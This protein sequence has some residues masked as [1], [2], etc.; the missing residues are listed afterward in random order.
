M[1]S[2]FVIKAN[3]VSSKLEDIL[4]GFFF[5]NGAE[6]ISENL[7]FSQLDEEYNVETLDKKNKDLS[8]YFSE[9]PAEDVMLKARAQFLE[10]IFSVVEEENKDWMAEWKKGFK[11]FE[12][13]KNVFV[14]PSWESKTYNGINIKIDPGMAF[15]TGTHSTTQI[16]AELLTSIDVKGKEVI[17][18]GTGTGILAILSEKLEAKLV[19]ATEIDDVARLVAKENLIINNCI[20]AKILDL[21]IESCKKSYGITIANIIDGVLIKIQEELIRVTQP[22]AYLILTG[23]LNERESGFLQKFNFSSFKQIK[24]IQKEEWVGFLYQKEVES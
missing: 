2:Y 21:Q 23:I 5:D 12:L 8:I 3:N 19:Q 10:V 20:N 9:P 17:D 6:G 11:S 22:G 1:K 7:Q 16:A 13:T 4:S 15:G 18:V 24:R 14:V